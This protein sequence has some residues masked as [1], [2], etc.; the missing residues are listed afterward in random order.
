MKAKWT[1]GIGV[2]AFALVVGIYWMGFQKK[3][4]IPPLLNREGPISTTSEWRN[5]KKAIE[6]LQQQIRQN[7]KDNKSKL[8]LAL[9]YMQEARITGEHP[10]YYPSALDLLEQV[11]DDSPET[12]AWHQEAMIAK[13]SV[14]LSLH[15]FKEAL[16]IG[17]EILKTRPNNPEVFGILCDAHVEL[18]QY[19]QAVQ[20]VDK[21]VSLKPDLRSYSRVSYVREIY[22]DL[23][24]AIE[25]M[26]LA[27]SA[28]FP[29]LEQTA[30]SRVTLG[31]LYEKQGDLA[32]AQLQY[33]IA[34]DETPHYAFAVAG[35][36]RIE[37]SK[38]NYKEAISL[39]QKA[40]DIIPEFSFT[41]EMAEVHELTGQKELAKK[42]ALSV[43]DMLQEDAGAG[44]F[45]DLELANL[46]AK[47]LNNC[48]KAL[49]YVEIE[50]EKR[51]DNIDV[52]KCLALIY[53]KKGDLIKA[54]QYAKVANRTHRQDPDL[55]M[56]SGLIG[57]K[58]GDKKLGIAL[59]KQSLH[60]D[61]F[62]QDELT[63]EAMALI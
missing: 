21:M 9:A 8:L 56:L 29:G 42:E 16:E 1:I 55:L 3:N 22:G 2:V 19:E 51:P 47:H 25:A 27:V 26:K 53:Y 36:A 40:A 57:Y 43:V 49:E 15:H 17:E 12:E 48:D 38:K 28:G 60:T 32:K 52:N 4:S 58:S 37:A 61:P 41:E 20:V 23:P 30:W 14:M 11:I 5:T 62:Q 35:L 45:V 13:A 34:L 44:H 7:S 10:Y 24:G 39:Y 63:K 59:I 54:S 6:G 18:G 46:Y 50:Y 33:N 31:K